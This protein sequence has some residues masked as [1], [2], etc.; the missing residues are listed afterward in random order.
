MI[1]LQWAALT[2]DPAAA[3]DEKPQH[4]VTLSCYNIY[5]KE[6]TNA[7]YDA[8]VGAGACFPNI[9][10]IADTPTENA[11]DPTYAEN[12]AVGV[13][14][15]MAKA[16]CDWAGGRLPTEA[17]W[18]YASR[19]KKLSLFP[20]GDAAPSCDL[21]NFKDCLTPADTLKVGSL[22]K[23]KS[24]FKLEDMSGNAW[25]WVFDWYAKDYYAHSETSGPIG[26]LN[27]YYK[28]VRG[29][30]YNS[31]ADYLRGGNRHAG[32]PYT[33]YMNVGF[34]CVTG[35]ITIPEGYTPPD[36]HKHGF[37]DHDPVDDDD[38][39][40]PQTYHRIWIPGTPLPGSQRQ[41]AFHH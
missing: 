30:G 11:A 4:D 2:A 38:P 1:H 22:T 31:V 7:M 34:R 24:S 16:Y 9:Q 13:D 23:G 12:P 33:P 35:P 25:E 40:K 10:P 17:E 32:D 15:N 41:P 26:P 19:G 27:G 28:V 20:W 8:C 37:P 21:A 39:D 14:Y 6:V 29:G 36:P 5:K 18:E 3:Q